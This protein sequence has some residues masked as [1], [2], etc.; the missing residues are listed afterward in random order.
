MA[1]LRFGTIQVKMPSGRA[2]SLLLLLPYLFCSQSWLSLG[3]PSMKV[4][5]RGRR[6]CLCQCSLVAGGSQAWHREDP[7]STRAGCFQAQ[8]LLGV[9]LEI[10]HLCSSSA[11]LIRKVASCCES[12][13]RAVLLSRKI[14]AALPICFIA[15]PFWM[16]NQLLWGAPLNVSPVSQGWVHLRSCCPCW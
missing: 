4:R 10:S 3:W 5:G 14:P 13:L 2:L 6:C 16:I 1:A 11:H 12:E 7:A 15:D 8:R 9:F